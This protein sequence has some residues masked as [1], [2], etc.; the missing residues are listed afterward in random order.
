MERRRGKKK[1]LKWRILGSIALI[2]AVSMTISSLAGYWYFE[3]IVREQ[4][5][6]DER[7]RLIQ[8]SGQ[9][10]FLAEDIRQ[11]A[12]SILIDAELQELLEEDVAGSAYRKQRRNNKVS[13][14]LIFYG[15][16]RGY[17]KDMI[18]R[19]EDGACYGSSHNTADTAYINEK[20]ARREIAGS[21]GQEGGSFS[22]PYGEGG[23]QLI[24]FQMQMFDKYRF[25]QRKGT[26]YI[27]FDPGY[28]LEPIRTY[29]GAENYVC[30]LG[31]GGNI[32]YGQDPDG[33]LSL[34]IEELA[35]QRE[36]IRRT[37]NGYLVCDTIEGTG[38][39]LGTL[40][41]DR[42]LWERSSFVLVFF[43]CSF[44]FSVGLILVFI[45]RRVERM[46]WPVTKLSAQME[47]VK[48]GSM[49]QIETVHT[50]D[51]IETLYNS[52][53]HML[54]QLKKGEEERIRYDRQK[55]KMQYEITMSQIHPHYLYNVLN[56]V[57]YLAAA[58]KHRDVAA[59]VRALI[60]T[61][62]NTLEIGGERVETTVKQELALTQSYLEIQ[63][64]RY[65]D[66]VTAKI[67]CD[68]AVLACRMPKIVIQP[69]VENAILHGI[70]PL[71]R[72]GTVRVDV[73]KKNETLSVS[74]EDDGA[75]IG[76]ECLKRF[77]NGEEI[78]SGK[79][80]RRHI[81]IQ[82]V[83]D[84]IWFLYG[85]EYGMEIERR[86]EGGTRV[87]LRLPFVEEQ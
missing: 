14:R 24:C 32:L 83:R 38:F 19:T 1:Q 16:L 29:A 5:I 78:S 18:I 26:L 52:F 41:T 27:E 58:E 30:L 55:H 47:T 65:P 9:L 40:V 6:S 44:L 64:Y 12:R 59:I 70:L 49:E 61:L 23:G 79:G 8:V 31:A 76:E 7:S 80:S 56:T 39:R 69:L 73:C 35:G 48:Y 68:E 71:E 57:V 86:K 67:C 42:Y 15:S 82:N 45:S 11:F 43:L 2:L 53:G 81:G 72:A 75:G 66:M 13:A 77:W 54:A 50:G 25:G 20:L 17:I 36:E 4:K 51:E 46:I 22:E 87:S 62:H 63:K 34:C 85:T 74:V 37:K 33:K 21:A 3:R 10:T 60:H 28:F 84:R